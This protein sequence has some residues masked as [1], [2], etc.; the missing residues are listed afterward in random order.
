MDLKQ[1]VVD[2]NDGRHWAVYGRRG[3]VA[4]SYQNDGEIAGDDP[5]TI[6]SPEPGAHSTPDDECPFLE[7]VCHVEVS[8]SGGTFVG[9]QWEEAGRDDQAVWRWLEEYYRDCLE[10]A[11]TGESP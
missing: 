4:W 5:V 1:C 9:G 6:H 7:G 8:D 2:R 10:Q 11:P 3:V